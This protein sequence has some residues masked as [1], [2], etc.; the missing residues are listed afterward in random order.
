[1]GHEFNTTDSHDHY[2]CGTC[3]ASYHCAKCEEGTGMYG[4]YTTDDDGG[5]FSCEDPERMKRMMKKWTEKM[6]AF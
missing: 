6:E 2:H 1:M 5:F 3:G 4:H